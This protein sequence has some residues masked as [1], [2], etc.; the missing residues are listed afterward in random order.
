[1]IDQLEDASVAR[2]R[3]SDAICTKLIT[4]DLAKRIASVDRGAD[5]EERLKESLTDVK[6]AGGLATLDV[7]KV[8][9]DGDKAVATV[10][11][12]TGDATKTSD[13]A[14]VRSGNSWRISAF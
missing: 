3:D 8:T 2:K 13:Y 6:D 1:M 4:A 5:C 12:E 9:I 11:A 7:K 14:L 10:E